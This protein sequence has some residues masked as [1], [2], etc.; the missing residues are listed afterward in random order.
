MAEIWMIC[1][2][3]LEYRSFSN[4]QMSASCK[5]VYTGLLWLYVT[6]SRYIHGMLFHPLDHPVSV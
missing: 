4:S 5:A 2:P 6:L 3:D 1:K